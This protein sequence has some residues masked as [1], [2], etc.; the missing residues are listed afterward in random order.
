MLLEP[1]HLGLGLDGTT[2]CAAYPIHR[3]VSTVA[4]LNQQS[5]SNRTGPAQAAHAVDENPSVVFEGAVF[6][7]DQA[8]ASAET[9]YS[10]LLEKG[11][12]V[13]LS[14]LDDHVCPRGDAG[15]DDGN[16]REDKPVDPDY[17]PDRDPAIETDWEGYLIE[18]AQQ[19]PGDIPS[20]LARRVG[21]L[22][23]S[24]VPWQTVLRR[25]VTRSFDRQFRWV[26]P[27]RRLL[28]QGLYLPG[29][30]G[31]RLDIAVAVDTS[32]STADLMPAF[33]AELKAILHGFG[34]YRIRLLACDAAIHSDEVIEDGEALP[35][36]DQLPGG[37]GTDFRPVFERLS[38]EP[39]MALVFLT[40]GYGPA[41]NE[42]PGWPTLWVTDSNGVQPANWG[43]WVKIQ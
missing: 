14:P 16:G 21:E 31:E 24:R 17:R 23:R 33:L 30:R 10:W 40:D 6:F 28:S 20:G 7:E 15:G 39:P 3:V 42:R 37:G 9:V 38:E 18:T 13:G 32:G 12:P 5:G 22:G 11:V 19:M 2:P 8:G 4:G 41:P 29:Q 43:E 25:F 1:F 36:L 34:R 26:P 35:I 27:N